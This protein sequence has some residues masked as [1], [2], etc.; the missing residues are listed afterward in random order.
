M[1][2]ENWKITW[3]HWTAIIHEDWEFNILVENTPISQLSAGIGVKIY[4][5]LYASQHPTLDV[6]FFLDES[7][8][9]GTTNAVLFETME[10]EE[11]LLNWWSMSDHILWEKYADYYFRGKPENNWFP[12]IVENMKPR[13]ELIQ[14]ANPFWRISKTL[15]HSLVVLWESRGCE[16]VFE[17]KWYESHLPFYLR[18]L[19]GTSISEYGMVCQNNS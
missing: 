11:L 17:K 16:I 18:L 3:D 12:P 2:L 10:E 4:R 9:H 14:N 5:A 15:A 7:N 13:A 6:H 19:S 8:C 1:K